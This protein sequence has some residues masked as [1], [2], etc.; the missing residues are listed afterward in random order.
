MIEY[1]DAYLSE[2]ETGK[3]EPSDE[4]LEKL[5]QVFQIPKEY[6]RHGGMDVEWEKIE[7][8]L[9]SMGINI[10][11]IEKIKPH[12]I[13]ALV[14]EARN[15]WQKGFT[16]GMAVRERHEIYLKRSIKKDID[17][18]IEILESGNTIAI[19]AI[20]VNIKAWLE[21]IRIRKNTNENKGG[22]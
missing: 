10:E 22:D 14:L 1:S 21:M 20:K 16:H 11:I 13:A 2:V 4:L 18:W 12:C 3:K 7:I 9:I 5:E 17:D 19:D 6:I 15:K 8:D